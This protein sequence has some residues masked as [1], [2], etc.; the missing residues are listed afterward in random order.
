VVLHCA[1]PVCV[2]HC[3]APDDVVHPW[4][5]N[6]HLQVTS[7][8][9]VWLA[10]FVPLMQDGPNGGTPALEFVITDGKG[11]WEKAAGGG[12]RGCWSLGLLA[13]PSVCECCVEG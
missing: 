5:A 2:W 6:V 12:C 3:Y 10:G 11:R 9:G 1:V 13:C 7:A 4:S 8:P